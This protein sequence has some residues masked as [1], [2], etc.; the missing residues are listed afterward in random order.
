MAPIIF[1]PTI[2]INGADNINSSNSAI[3]EHLG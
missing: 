2:K 3:E 1:S